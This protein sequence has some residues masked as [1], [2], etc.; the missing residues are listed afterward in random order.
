MGEI[1]GVVIGI[2]IFLIGIP[3]IGYISIKNEFGDGKYTKARDKK[4]E[5]KQNVNM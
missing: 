4:D 5:V 2:L 3:Y 1:I